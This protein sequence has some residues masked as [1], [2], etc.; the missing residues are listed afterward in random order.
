[1]FVPTQAGCGECFG[2]GEEGCDSPNATGIAVSV[3]SVSCRLR[4]LLSHLPSF[5]RLVIIVRIEGRRV[6][7]VCRASRGRRGNGLRLKLSL[8][9]WRGHDR[10]AEEKGGASLPR[11]EGNTV[12]EPG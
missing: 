10:S 6:R 1:M 11:G 2:V 7:E 9:R 12:F 8:S 4:I 3:P 5:C